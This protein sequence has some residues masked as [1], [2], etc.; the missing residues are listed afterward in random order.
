M[1]DG[2]RYSEN[3]FLMASSTGLTARGFSGARRLAG[4]TT[5]VTQSYCSHPLRGALRSTV[6]HFGWPFALSQSRLS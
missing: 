1:R 3:I 2:P 4:C 6:F 5:F